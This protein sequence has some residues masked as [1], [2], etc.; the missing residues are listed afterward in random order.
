MYKIPANTLFLGKNLV[1][2]PECH[3]TNDLALQLSQKPETPE[4][5]VVITNHQTAGRGQ[6]GNTWHAAPG[7]NLTFSVIVKPAF[8][9]LKDQFYLNMVTSLAVRDLLKNNIDSNIEVKWPNDV[10]INGKKVC[11]ILVENQIHGSRFT[12]SVIG[13]GLN[14][15]QEEFA[16][17]TAT[18]L[19][20]IRGQ[21]VDLAGTL[22]ILLANLESRYLQ[23]RQ[24]KLTLLKDD[25]LRALYWRNELHTFSSHDK[26][27]EGVIR[28]VDDIGRLQVETDEGLRVFDLK[29][30]SYIR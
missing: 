5:T 10:L 4:G 30:I 22:E 12:N 28:N 17:P 6:R 20:L 13:I 7:M 2:V 26:T 21:K 25:Y 16:L 9:A 8:L 3:S 18:S 15:N 1:F 27:F 14:I 19:A 11:G 24:Q 29:E 23:L